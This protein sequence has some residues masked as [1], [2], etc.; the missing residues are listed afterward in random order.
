[1]YQK[2]IF[3]FADDVALLDNEKALEETFSFGDVEIG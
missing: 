2:T 1:M 3:I